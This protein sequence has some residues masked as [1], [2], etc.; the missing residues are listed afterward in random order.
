MTSDRHLELVTDHDDPRPRDEAA[1]RA[2]LGAM[3]RGDRHALADITTTITGA[4]YYQPRHEL[5]HDACTHLYARG[6]TPDPIAVTDHLRATGNLTRAGGPAYL[7]ELHNGIT[8]TANASYYADIIARLAGRRRLLTVADT[9]RANAHTP[10]DATLDD[11]LTQARAHLDT[12]PTRPPGIDTD[13]TH[14]WA[15][16]DLADILAN[17]LDAPTATLATRR[18]GKHLL[19]PGAVHSIAG[20]PASGK[21]WF[22]IIAAA[23]E[24]DDDNPVL[25][26]DF[27]D[28]PQT[29]VGRLKALGT[30]D[31]QI[32]THLRYVRPH[33]ALDPTGWAQLEN[34]A[35][36]ARLVVID[37]ITEAMTLH[38]LS[39]MDNEDVARWLALLPRRLADHG[40]AVLQ[41]DHVVKNAESRGRYAIGGQHKLA[42]IDGAAY[43]MVVLKSFGKGVHGQGKIV[44]DKDRHG[45]V[46]PIG[47]T[48][49][50]I[51]LD[52][53]GPDGAL[54]GWL[55][56]PEASHD[57]DGNFRPTTLMQR[58]SDFLLPCT[59]AVSMTAVKGGVKGNDKHIVTAVET[60]AREGYVRLDEGTR[61]ARMVTLLESFP[62]AES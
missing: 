9:I 1:E 31:D 62:R 24:L 40:P 52:A 42:G 10:S 11:L 28:R 57:E 55:D 13:H 60:L 51:H 45:D 43:K 8:I 4:D 23:Q 39:L 2:T 48:A 29:L 49:A 7:H 54:Y 33:T 30:T 61:G 36:G 14:P 41:I 46:G 58:V 32:L 27:E 12:I 19:Y 59:A 50:D 15:P 34:A 53:T 6:I 35:A 56:S 21:T 16:L 38:G 17:N 22:A 18:D 37:G 3:L 44:I 25:Y 20:E 5:I 47:A 26:I